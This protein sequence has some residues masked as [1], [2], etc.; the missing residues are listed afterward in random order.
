MTNPAAQ[1]RSEDHDTSA[2]HDRS[3]DHNAVRHGTGESFASQLALWPESRTAAL[4]ASATGS[5]VLDAVQRAEAGETLHPEDLAALLSE[6]AVPHLER[7][8]EAAQALTLR[9]FGRTVQLFTPL[10]L[11]NHCTNRCVYCGFNAG[12]RIPRTQM[13]MDAIAEEGARIAATGLRHILLLTGDARARSGPDYIAEAARILRPFFPGIGIEVYAMSVAE[14]AAL[15]EAGVDS[16]TMFQETYNE[17]LYATLHP[18]GPKRDFHFRLDALD[19]G[20]QAGLRSLNAGGLLGLDGW[21]RESFCTALHV[22]WLQRRHPGAELAISVPR[23]RP[24]V[25][26]PIA[27]H[28][29]TDRDLVQIILAHR[30]FLPTAGIVVSSRERAFLRDQLI[31]LGVTRLSAG[32]STRVG[33]H[34]ASDEGSPQFEIADPRTVAEMAAAVVAQGFQP[35]FKHWEPLDGAAYNCGTGHPTIASSTGVIH[36]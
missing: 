36:V 28:E 17:T 31:R 13:D 16:L 23:M 7:M 27:V 4:L 5:A 14:Y 15:A 11:A 6:A 9:H 24:H 12:N 21:Q 35:V 33:G 10:Y 18:A 2:N 20:G 26:S 32:V 22:G 25:G 29:V 8:A 19:R 3:A 34:A 30:L 1:F